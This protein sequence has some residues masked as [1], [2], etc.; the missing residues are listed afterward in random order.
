MRKKVLLGLLILL[1]ILTSM[2]LTSCEFTAH[3]H[4]FQDYYPEGVWDEFE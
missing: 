2:S 1:T 4:S 3:Q